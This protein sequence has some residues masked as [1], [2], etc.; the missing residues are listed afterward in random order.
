[1]ENDLSGHS[2]C[3]IS[4]CDNKEILTKESYYQHVSNDLELC[5][6]KQDSLSKS[7]ALYPL[8]VIRPLTTQRI[9]DHFKVTM[10]Y[11][12]AKDLRSVEK[13]PQLAKSEILK[14][15]G[16]NKV[17][18]ND[19]HQLVRQRLSTVINTPL[20]QQVLDSLSGVPSSYP[21]ANCH[22]DF[23]FKNLIYHSGSVYTFDVRNSFVQSRLHDVATLWLSVID[24]GLRD[25]IK[26]MK[27]SLD[28]Y[29]EFKSQI[30]LIRQ[31]RILE[32]YNPDHNDKEV[33]DMHEAWFNAE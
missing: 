17:I 6:Q 18:R 1:M 23:G 19:L 13:I 20:R 27:Q 14:Y 30:R 28:L 7:R 25:Q 22:G 2:G 31:V 32:F 10:R 4:V 11:I 15:L 16:A 12:P 26:L 3:Q 5:T 21:F 24:S 8:K 29:P 33:S 9:G